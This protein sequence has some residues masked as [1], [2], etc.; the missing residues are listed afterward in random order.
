MAHQAGDILWDALASNLHFYLPEHPLKPPAAN[1]Y[2]L[3]GL[4]QARDI[5]AFI[6]TFIRTISAHTLRERQKYPEKYDPPN[7]EDVVLDNDTVNR[8]SRTVYRWRLAAGSNGF[9]WDKSNE[10]K[11]TSQPCLHYTDENRR[12]THDVND[13]RDRD[14]DDGFQFNC[15]CTIPFRE[16]KA[17]AFLRE[18][19]I[20]YCYCFEGVNKGGFFNLE[21]IK[22]LLIHGEIDTVLR[23]CAHPDVKYASWKSVQNCACMEADLGWNHLYSLALD[24]YIVLNIL[25]CFPKLRGSISGRQPPRSNESYERDYRD[26]KIYQE[27]LYKCTKSHYSE[28][29]KHIHRQFFGIKDD[30]FG[31]SFKIQRGLEW[32]ILA[33]TATYPQSPDRPDN[34]PLFSILRGL[35]SW[36]MKAF[37]NDDDFP[38]GNVPFEIF[39]NCDEEAPWVPHK[40]EVAECYRTLRTIGLPDELICEIAE[41]AYG[42]YGDEPWRRLLV[43]HD[44]FHPENYDELVGY[45]GSCWDIMVRCNIFAEAVGNPINW[46][47]ELKLCLRRLFRSPR[48]DNL[49]WNGLDTDMEDLIFELIQP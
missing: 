43:A 44:P 14:Y 48:G 39:L 34:Q 29:T 3:S 46:Q 36:R 4:Y 11:L 16:R 23:V 6:F 19:R 25:Y 37:I 22:T 28:V 18:C 13:P 1:L 12:Y 38:F 9:G 5:E 27:M 47:S 7:E 40:L 31:N 49:D 35:R 45:L 32:P 24:A 17:H 2:I 30:Y 42:A 10:V 21:V 8:I 26:T 15:D 41:L 20:N 33:K